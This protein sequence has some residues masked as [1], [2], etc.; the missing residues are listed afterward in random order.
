MRH[1]A[2]A[3][4]KGN[5]NTMT[6]IYDTDDDGNMIVVFDT[7]WQFPELLGFSPEDPEYKQLQHMWETST[8]KR[9]PREVAE[10]GE[11]EKADER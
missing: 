4:L 5:H 9:I 8:G 6:T 2:S 7:R 10:D 11:E 1:H 3:S